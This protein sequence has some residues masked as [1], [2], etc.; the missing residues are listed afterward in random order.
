MNIT[1]C[2]VMVAAVSAFALSAAGDETARSNTKWPTPAETGKISEDLIYSVDR[3]PERLFDTARSVEVITLDEIWRKSGRT[4]SDLLADEAGII[5]KRLDYSVASPMIRGLS[6]KQVLILIDGM[7]INSSTWGANREYLNFIDINLIERIEIVRGVVSVLGTE[8][9][10]GVINIIT[11]KGSPNGE[12]FGASLITR[13]SSG[14]RGFATPV[15]IYGSGDRY[16]FFADV[17]FFHT[18]NMRA[19][20]DVGGIPN[21]GYQQKGGSGSL[22]YLI[23]PDKSLTAMVTDFQ[24]N[25][26]Q[27]AGLINPGPPTPSAG[28]YTRYDA[29]PIRLRAAHVVY[30]DVANHLFSDS[31]RVSLGWTHQEIGR[32]RVRVSAP[33]TLA[34][35]LDRTSMK[36]LNL[37]LGKFLGAHHLVYGI[38]YSTEAIHSTAFSQNLVTGSVTSQRGQYMDGANYRTSGIYLN[39]RFDIGNWLTVVAGTRYGSFASRGR[40]QSVVGELSI[41]STKSAFTETLNLSFHA[42]PHLNLI[43]NA[44]RGFRAPNIDELARYNF[45]PAAIEIPAPNLEPEKVTS[46]EAGLKFDHP[47]FAAS[48]FYFSNHFRELI[49]RRPTTF[50]G[51]PCLRPDNSRPCSPNDPIFVQNANWINMTRHGYEMEARYHL[52]PSLV[53][54]SGYTY[55]QIADSTELP[56]P[57]GS[58]GNVLARYTLTS[59]AR[60]PWM[61]IQHLFQTGSSSI[62]GVSTSL[63]RFAEWNIR[64]GMN[65]S[66]NFRFTL[67]VQNLLDRENLYPLSQTT[68]Q[69]GRQLIVATELRF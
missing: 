68:Y 55:F 34:N 3:V 48:A 18:Q 5:V 6:G 41:N 1:K 44:I 37:E 22:Q 61:E 32:D 28:T 59:S 66:R 27:R 2:I 54:H 43:A 47:T 16:R 17:N 65:V 38:D 39:D 35:Q 13:Y 53:L 19:G 50:N 10:G 57:H 15:Q 46:Y 49:T 58:L 62:N 40:E 52:T 69:P 36:A 56:I 63:P 60:A 26:V 42:G 12:H 30:E 31:L 14:D 67:G 20:G 45:G 21:S 23:A 51:Q 8:S 64:G 25:G 9:L 4:L 7:K 33:T 29:K 24:E 11:R